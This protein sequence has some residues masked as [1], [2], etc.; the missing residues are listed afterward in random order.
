MSP[1]IQLLE[2]KVDGMYM[3][4]RTIN[5]LIHQAKKFL[6]LYLLIN[7][8]IWLLLLGKIKPHI[9]NKRKLKLLQPLLQLKL[10]MLRSL[11]LNSLILLHLEQEIYHTC[12]GQMVHCISLVPKMMPLVKN[13]G[14]DKI[15]TL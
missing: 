10:Q 7:I 6:D 5:K 1:M 15:K 2:P 8:M 3:M 11:S 4:V 12:V 13:I 14:L 9:I